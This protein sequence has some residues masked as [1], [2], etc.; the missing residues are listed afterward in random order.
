MGLGLV[1]DRANP[2]P[3]LDVT[4]LQGPRDRT[5]LARG[6]PSSERSIFSTLPLEPARC[7]SPDAPLVRTAPPVVCVVPMADARIVHELACSES[8]F[9]D[10]LFFDDEFNRRLFLEELHFS[11]WRVVRT[12]DTNADLVEQEVE[13]TP[14][15]GDL[16]GPLRAIIGE[17]I[18]YHEVGK[19][20]RKRR[21]YAV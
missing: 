2:L 17:G 8:V 12:G 13:A 9:W 1:G 14:P 3:R 7:A 11:G 5:S 6:A 16:P 18:S 15:I 4:Q 19:C 10:K 20:D 21:R